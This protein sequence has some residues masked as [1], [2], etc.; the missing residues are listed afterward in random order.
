MTRPRA[1]PY[2]EQREFT[3]AFEVFRDHSNEFN[4]MVEWIRNSVDSLL[5][6]SVEFSM[7]SV[8]CGRG[9]FDLE[10]IS[11][12]ASKLRRL[13]YDAVDSDAVF[14]D[15]FQ[16]GLRSLRN[17][18]VDFSIYHSPFE[19]YTP[20][21]SYDL[22]VFS[23]CLYYIP[24]RR[25]AISKAMGMLGSAGSILIFISME[26]SIQN[27]RR[28]PDTNGA[29]PEFFG[30][31]KLGEMLEQGGL[32]YTLE[33]IDCTLDVTECFQND[34]EA[35]RLL[36]SFLLSRNSKYL[37]EDLVSE[38]LKYLAQ[39]SSVKGSRRFLSEPVGVFR[40]VPHNLA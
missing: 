16:S 29:A 34:S 31:E 23:H 14:C 22:V 27:M 18:N 1:T 13:R 19:S 10:V 12:F 38:A 24:D 32:S 36:L 33:T 35:G 30:G 26:P 3:A 7:L 5:Q 17:G 40:I 39:I 9:D 28:L 15:V 37:T 21:V 8:G 6:G 25:Q 2:L 4:L 11:C 20:E